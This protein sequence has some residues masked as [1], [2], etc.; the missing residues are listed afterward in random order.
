MALNVETV[1]WDRANHIQITPIKLADGEGKYVYNVFVDYPI[2]KIGSYDWDTE[3]KN[4]TFSFRS[5]AALKR[6]LNL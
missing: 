3:R 1:D 6:F 4:N 2:P 5:I